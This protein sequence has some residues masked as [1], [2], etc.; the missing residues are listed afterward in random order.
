MGSSYCHPENE[1]IRPYVCCARRGVFKLLDKRR[2]H[3]NLSSGLSRLRRPECFGTTI[4]EGGMIELALTNALQHAGKAFRV[5]ESRTEITPPKTPN[6][7][8]SSQYHSAC[9]SCQSPN[10]MSPT[11]KTCRRWSQNRN[12]CVLQSYR[13]LGASGATQHNTSTV[14]EQCIPKR[15]YGSRDC[16]LCI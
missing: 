4:V 7:N 1:F 16:V 9:L 15:Q 13:T 10:W 11:S 5:L 3:L 2:I 14:P 6:A 12:I 8:V